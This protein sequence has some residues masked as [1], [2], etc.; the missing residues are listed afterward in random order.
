[1]PSLLLSKSVIEVAMHTILYIRQIYPAELFDRRRLFDI[2]VFQCIEPSINDYVSKAIKAVGEEIIEDNVSKVIIN[3]HKSDKPLEKF[4]FSFDRP[5]DSGSPILDPER[6]PLE[7]LQRQ[8]RAMLLKLNTIDAQL[9]PLMASS[10][11]SF[12]FMMELREENVHG[13]P[14]DSFDSDVSSPDVSLGKTRG[15]ENQPEV[16]TTYDP[17]LVHIIRAGAFNVSL[18]VQESHAKELSAQTR[19]GD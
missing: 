11:L 14:E 7:V 1:M 17:A 2:P 5:K 3:I 6:I 15:K 16:C 10:N 18:Y 12:S 13:F 4:I 9:L 19:H 8:M